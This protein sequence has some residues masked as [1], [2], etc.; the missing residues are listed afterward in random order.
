[1]AGKRNEPDVF[2]I[3]DFWQTSHWLEG[4]GPASDAQFF[5][6]QLNHALEKEAAL[7]V[8]LAPSVSAHHGFFKVPFESGEGDSATA[9]APSLAESE[10][11]SDE[12]SESPPDLWLELQATS[13]QATQALGFQ[14]WQDFL[15]RTA[16]TYR[17]SLISEAGPETYDALLRWNRDPLQLGNAQ[18]PVVTTQAYLSSLLALAL[19]RESVLFAKD[20]QG[21]SFK[22]VLPS[23]RVSGVSQQTLQGL[24]KDCLSCGSAFLALRSF[25]HSTYAGQADRCGIALASASSL[26]LHSI[27]EHVLVHLSRPRSP[28]QLQTMVQAI[29]AI[30]TPFRAL[31]PHV[32][33]GLTDE[34]LMSF[35][36]DLA[37]AA[38]HNDEFVHKLLG[39]ILQTISQPWLRFVEEWIGT[40]REPGVPLTKLDPGTA[41]GFIKIESRVHV[42]DFGE[43]VEEPDFTLDHKRIPR[44]VSDELASSIFETGRNLRF[45]RTSHPHH[46]LAQ[47]G[48]F[49]SQNPP[50]AAWAYTWDAIEQL[51]QRVAAYRES[52][53]L[54]LRRGPSDTVPAESC[55]IASGTTGAL[56]VFGLDEDEIETNLLNSME[57][58]AQPPS[59]ARTGESA[60]E[61]LRILVQRRLRGDVTA[62]AKGAASTPSWSLLSNL[63]FGSIVAT[64]ARIINLESL[65][66]LF[67]SHRLRDH[68]RLQHAFHMLGNGNFC[69]RLSHALFD[70]D[71]ESAER[72]AG[73]AMQGDTMGLR[74]GRRESWPPASSELRLALMGVLVE[75]YESHDSSSH[76]RSQEQSDLPG[77]LSFAVR[78]LSTEEINKCMNADS[79]EALDFLRLSYQTPTELASVVTPSLLTHYDRIFKHLLRVLR[80]MHVV[81]QLFRDAKSEESSWKDQ[82]AVTCRFEFEARHFVTSIFAYFLDHGV[83][84]PWWAFERRLD[85]LEARLAQSDYEHLGD[86]QPSPDYVLSQHAQTLDQ[87]T[88]ALFL[89]KRQQPVLKLLEDVFNIILVYAQQSRARATDR[90]IKAERT[91][92]STIYK[93]FKKKVNIFITVCRG[94]TEKS[95]MASGAGD[96][97]MVSQLLVKLD[98]FEHYAKRHSRHK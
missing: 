11:I 66:L 69:S 83:G 15:A 72:H 9:A 67:N 91:A 33:R 20:T 74:L 38:E 39:E 41:K 37:S 86:E 29:T 12:S 89:R 21:T 2:A 98:L 94:L 65:R 10:P 42:D 24:Q 6:Q 26:V 30:L 45:I 57:Q 73:V 46:A 95:Q 48:V 60:G 76:R 28:L 22:P 16:P 23:M 92:S 70:P 61:S 1:M 5:S 17:P 40:R 4:I 49:E 78:D 80:M 53:L 84:L 87:I 51:E 64:Q 90:S 7:L 62:D 13:R 14:T 81:N 43:E 52:L 68:L 8:P 27:Q 58:L 31:T 18:I 32:G 97:N 36:F 96:G 82:D 25:V 34:D 77:D 47:P 93:E 85:E 88:S 56:G 54:A 59:R 3:P 44:F 75:S 35:V 55:P 79:L 50:A 19:G 63:S 71:L